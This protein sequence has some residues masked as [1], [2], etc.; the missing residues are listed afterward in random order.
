MRDW[1]VG[2]SN[3]DNVKVGSVV[4]HPTQEWI[5]META[6]PVHR[7]LTRNHPLGDF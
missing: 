1:I 6:N 3:V 7:F 4:P 2:L 5:G